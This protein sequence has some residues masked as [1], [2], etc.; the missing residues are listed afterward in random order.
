M[1]TYLNRFQGEL[2]LHVGMSDRMTY[3]DPRYPSQ[4]GRLDVTVGFRDGRSASVELIET[5]DGQAR[6]ELSARGHNRADASEIIRYIQFAISTFVVAYQEAD[7]NTVNKQKV[8]L[9]AATLSAQSVS[10]MLAAE[11]DSSKQLKIKRLLVAAAEY[12]RNG[13]QSLVLV[14]SILESI[15]PA[16]INEAFKKL[17]GNDSFWAHAN[18]ELIGTVAYHNQLENVP[19]TL[20]LEYQKLALDL[21]PG[22]KQASWS[23][24]VR[25][26]IWSNNKPARQIQ[27]GRRI[28]SN[29]Y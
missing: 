25:S 15:E 16:L 12:W 3:S 10:A 20:Q 6:V 8:E 13:D 28:R 9:G 22:S 21:F 23:R 19:N 14:S 11:N 17:L 2:Q 18:Y 26:S 27:I 7:Q 5:P 1:N 29:L 4:P 24:P